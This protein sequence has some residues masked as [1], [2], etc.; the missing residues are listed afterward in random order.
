MITGMKS[1]SFEDKDELNLA[2]IAKKYSDPVKARE[3]LE[4]LRW[5]NGVTCPHCQNRNEKP[6]SKL[7]PRSEDGGVRDGVYFCGACRKQ[8]TVTV[9]SI[10]EGSHIP[11]AKWLMAI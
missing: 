1:K 2:S 4:A 8:F 6:I 3:L 9:K 7:K 5:P 10:F 11:I